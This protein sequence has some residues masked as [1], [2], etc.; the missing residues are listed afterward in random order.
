M[1]HLG[2]RIPCTIVS[3]FLISCESEAFVTN[4][5]DAPLQ[6]QVAS[7][8][9]F[10]FKTYQVPP[11]LGGLHSIYVGRNEQFDASR[12]LVEFES[13]TIL[14]WANFEID[15]G[16]FQFTLDSTFSGDIPDE[17]TI[18]M[19]YFRRDSNYVEL[20]SNYTNVDWITEDFPKLSSRFASDTTGLIHLRFSV[21]STLVT[22]LGDTAEGSWLYLLGSPEDS[23]FM[24]KFYSSDS[25]I[26][27]PILRIFMHQPTDDSDSS[28]TVVD[29]TRVF[30]GQSDA[31]LFIPPSLENGL[32]DSSY[33][34][35][36]VAAGLVTVVKADLASMNIPK[37]ASVGRA[38]LILTIDEAHSSAGALDSLFFQAYALEDTVTNWGWGEV[39]TEDIYNHLTASFARSFS[40]AP[41]GSVLKLDVTD[42][43][44]SLISEREVDDKTIVNLGFKLKM[45]N[46][47]SIFDYAAVRS[48]SSALGQPLLELFYEIP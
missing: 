24:L 1:N 25:P 21:D 37:N 48:D 34:Y 19:G 14:N 8:A 7:T 41:S 5:D 10:Q 12:T 31:T 40:A 45:I 33:S 43:L 11:T 22:T 44:Q 39:L 35:I 28:E 23:D 6:S 3:L 42:L 16:Y 2:L 47:G 18:T 29:S 17:S 38:K 20:E 36:G 9:S 32:F 27:G 30:N 15:S 13:H 46:S 4:L 26:Y